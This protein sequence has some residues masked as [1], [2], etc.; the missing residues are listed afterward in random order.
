MAEEAPLSLISF[1]WD[2]NALLYIATCLVLPFSRTAP[3]S[4]RFDAALLR[5]LDSQVLVEF[6]PRKD[7]ASYTNKMFVAVGVVR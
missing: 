2:P 7:L 1:N 6:S 5:Q 3:I 4:L